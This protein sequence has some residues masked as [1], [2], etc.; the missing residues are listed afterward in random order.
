MAYTIL[1]LA[2][3]TKTSDRCINLDWSIYLRLRKFPFGDLV[4]PLLCNGERLE[5]YRSLSKNILPHNLAKGIP[6]ADNSIDAVYHSH[7]LEHLD[8]SVATQFLSDVLRVLKPGGIHRIVVPDF[9]HDCQMYVADF[10]RSLA[11][12][13]GSEHEHYIATI[14]DQIVRTE[15]WSTAHQSRG[16][17]FLENLLLGDARKR[18][19]LH[20]WM[21]DF[22]SLSHILK[23]VGFREVIR[24]DYQTSRVPDWSTTLLDLNEAG[25]EY[26]PSSLYVEAVK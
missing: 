13:N 12:G 6:Y 26:K 4:A 5:R 15:S 1:N 19:E 11:T 20:R 16:R 17:R 25:T 9:A 21:Y 23:N 22:V 7:F 2:C 24:C 18:G 14:L 10:E 8:R 3:G